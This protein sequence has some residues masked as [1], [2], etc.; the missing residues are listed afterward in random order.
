[1][2]TKLTYI[3]VINLN[4]QTS[5]SENDSD[6][7]IQSHAFS[8]TTWMAAVQFYKE[9]GAVAVGKDLL[10]RNLFTDNELK[11]FTPS[12]KKAKDQ[13]DINR[14]RQLLGMY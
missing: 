8:S 13:L 7:E 14:Q 2:Y 5:K 11:E 12:G 6:D 1:M 10:I 9:H 3:S 4:P